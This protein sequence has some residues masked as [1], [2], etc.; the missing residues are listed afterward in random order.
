MGQ[1]LIIT[2]EERNSILNA[3]KSNIFEAEPAGQDPKLQQVATPT[4][5][6]SAV[7]QQSASSQKIM[8]LQNKLNEKF[9]SGLTPDGK[10]V[11]KT[12]NAILI[13]LKGLP[14]QH[15]S[16]LKN[17]LLSPNNVNLKNPGLKN[18]Y[19]NPKNP[20]NQPLI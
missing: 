5:Q 10:W 6:P 12:A 9:N 16:K 1:R 7:P 17:P 18:P 8:Q 19:V 2:E 4:Q 11:A 15:T 3:H 20:L 14:T 13:A